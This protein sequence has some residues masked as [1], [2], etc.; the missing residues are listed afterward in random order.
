MRNNILYIFNLNEFKVRN[1]LD[2]LGSQFSRK[3]LRFMKRLEFINTKRIND[4]AD[5][6]GI[7]GNKFVVTVQKWYFRDWISYT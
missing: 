2:F 1:V 4:L 3:R 5:Y 7:S 6:P